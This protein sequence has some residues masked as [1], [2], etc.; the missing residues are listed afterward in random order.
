MA[1]KGI[2]FL[3]GNVNNGTVNLSW[4]KVTP[5]FEKKEQEEFKEFSIY[6]KPVDDFTFGS[7]YE[8][9][10]C[11]LAPEPVD[12]IY[13]GPVECSNNRKYLF[14]DRQA[15]IGKVYGY[16]VKTRT[17]PPVGPVPLKI[18]DPEVW[19]SY[20]TLKSKLQQLQQDYPAM[21]NLGVC[22][23]TVEGR[24][25]LS[26]K[27]GSGVTAL[28]LA[29]AMHPGEAGPELIISA[30]EK[31]LHESPAIL[32]KCA[33]VVIPSI[34]I[35]VRERLAQGRP[36]YLRK[37]IAGVDLNRNFPAEWDDIGKEYGLSTDDPES[38]TYRGMF[39]AS[40]PETKAV[41]KFFAD[42]K[43]AV[44]F[45]FHALAGI[46]DIPA[47]GA[48]GVDQSD[49]EFYA[50][51]KRFIKAYGTGLHP[52]L[53]P[54]DSWL[55]FGGTGGSFMRWAWHELRIPAFD[56]ELSIVIA[57]D[58]LQKCRVDHTDRG[59]LEEYAFR[60]SRAVMNILNGSMHGRKQCRHARPV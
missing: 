50:L 6:R 59:L 41:M 30:L 44:I 28:G 34:N 20:E 29:G 38:L 16:F 49:S 14:Q 11:G 2:S 52:E 48:G 26:L 39:P 56:L 53:T 18:R 3:N 51:S 9:F 22:G 12:L 17:L 23:R 7:D 54:D 8:E 43:P 5:L 19:W 35:D 37:N 42:N 21:V 15:E 27:I 45:S 40:E 24:E 58:A 25:I 47:V 32:K 4:Y 10:F 1:R 60:H 36:W 31:I 13:C 55:T 57:P 46:C 33:I